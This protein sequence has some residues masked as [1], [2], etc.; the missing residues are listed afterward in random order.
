MCIGLLLV[1]F[2]ALLEE[3]DERRQVG[4]QNPPFWSPW[5]PL[6]AP[7]G[8]IWESFLPLRPLLDPTVATFGRLVKKSA[9]WD[10]IRE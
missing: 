10:A 1:R 8:T 5:D 6:L 9:F 3:G 2:V 4:T 7:W